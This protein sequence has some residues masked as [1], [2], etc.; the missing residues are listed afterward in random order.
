MD[1]IEAKREL[2]QE[3]MSFLG[4]LA[5]GMEETLGET[6]TSISIKA[7]EKFGKSLSKGAAHTTNIQEALAELDQLLVA[8]NCLWHIEC[9]KPSAQPEM[10]I[11]KDD[12]YEVMLVFRDCMIRQ[13]LFR[14]GHPQKGSLCHL[15]SGFLSAAMESITGNQSTVE[16]VHAGENA[17]YKRLIIKTRENTK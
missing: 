8:N 7:G 9:F 14:Y 17:C 12:G 1:N 6:S 16:I 10:T 13:A 3:T 4:A 15:T 5:C 11:P 2:V